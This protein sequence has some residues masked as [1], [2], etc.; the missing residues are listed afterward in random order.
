VIELATHM[1]SKEELH[2]FEPEY[3]LHR[4]QREVC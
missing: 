1:K 2:K 3:L 4:S